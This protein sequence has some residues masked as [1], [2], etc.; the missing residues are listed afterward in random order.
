MPGTAKDVGLN[1]SDVN[2]PHKSAEAAARYLSQLL[3]QTGGDLN[4]ALAAYNWGIGNV[5]KKG[6]ENA[7]QETRDYVP[8]VLGGLRPGSGMAVE[9]RNPSA[10]GPSKTEYHIGSMAIS[11]PAQSVSRLTE[12][13]SKRAQNRVRIIAFNSGQQ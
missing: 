9:N 13:I 10:L 5:Q 7:P 11:S 3:K 8:K 1:G 12:D 4:S 6:L 2:D